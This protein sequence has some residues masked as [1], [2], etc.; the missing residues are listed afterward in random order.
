MRTVKRLVTC[1]FCGYQVENDE[2]YRSGFEWLEMRV[3]S[4]GYMAARNGP[5][6]DICPHCYE[7]LERTMRE[8]R[9]EAGLHAETE[10]P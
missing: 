10:T 6:L 9:K 8:I 1:D 3:D 4:F 7:R 2:V 5:V